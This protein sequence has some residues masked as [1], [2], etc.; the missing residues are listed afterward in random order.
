[1]SRSLFIFETLLVHMD[2]FMEREKSL[3]FTFLLD[4]D[5]ESVKSDYAVSQREK[6]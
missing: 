4:V 1:M 5:L 2:V 3:C 6:L